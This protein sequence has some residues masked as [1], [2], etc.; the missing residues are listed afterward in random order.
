MIPVKLTMRNF[1][2]YRDNVAPLHFDGLHLACLSGDNGNGKSAIIDAMTWALWGKT[3][4]GSDDDLI[5]A[6]QPD[7][8]VEFEFRIGEQLYRIIRKRARPRKAG[9]AGQ[10]ALEFQAATE[11]GFRAITGD[12]MTRTQQEIIGRLHM[13]YDTFVNSAYLRQGHA[14][15]FTIKRPAERKEVLADILGLSRY[16]ELEERAR[17]MA[18]QQEAE[19]AQLESAI[20]DIGEELANK[21]DYEAEL[22]RAQE[23]LAKIEAEVKEKEADLNARRQQ[24]DTLESRK[25]Q[26]DELTAQTENNNRLLK[27]WEQQAEQHRVRIQEY[28]A[29]IGRRAAI[30][31]GYGKY[32]ECKKTNEELY[33][34]SQESVR[35]EKQRAQLDARIKEAGH[36]LTREHALVQQRLDDLEAKTRQLP[37]L[38]ER[39]GQAQAQASQLAGQE[40]ALRQ[41]EQELQEA[42][43]QASHLESETARLG[44]EI[45]E[46]TEKLDLISSHLASHT[47]AKCPLCETELTQEGLALIQNKYTKK[48]RKNRI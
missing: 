6:G 10:S 12:T 39:L 1:M 28:E 26:L 44:R 31:E 17:E 24:K 16:D 41:K 11:D 45:G 30:E 15:E 37:A 42:Q 29:I 13:D 4:A 20:G 23:E 18:R 40:A 47:E 27:S 32:E 22:A 43:R 33:K 46:V 48:K 7:M 3:R 38:K 8:E 9:G 35:L 21:A 25:A 19:R 34:K 2:C 14:D 5:H 36:E